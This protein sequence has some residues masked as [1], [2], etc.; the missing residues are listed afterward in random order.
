M[1]NMAA[2]PIHGKNLYKSFLSNQWIDSFE[3]WYV[4]LGTGVL[5]ILFK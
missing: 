2:M 4:A 5:P 1:T 3:I